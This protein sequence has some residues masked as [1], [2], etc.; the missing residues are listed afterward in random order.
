MTVYAKTDH[1]PQNIEI[2]FF[3]SSTCRPFADNDDVFLVSIRL[4]VLKLYDG[5]RDTVENVH[6]KKRPF[7]IPYWYFVY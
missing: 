3:A 7:P 5:K 1:S 2:Q 4:V 6:F